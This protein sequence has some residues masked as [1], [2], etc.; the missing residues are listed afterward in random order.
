M[1][2]T[3]ITN[4]YVQI[5]NQDA[6]GLTYDLSDHVQSVD[7]KYSRATPDSTSMGATSQGRM[8]GLQDCTITLN[9]FQDYAAGKVDEALWA[10]FNASA[11]AEI[12]IKPA[13]TAVSATNPRYYGNVI[14]SN[15]TPAS[16]KVGDIA[17]Q[18]ITLPADGA[19]TRSIT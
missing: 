18:N 17:M 19:I 3:T 9:L 6:G 15:Y 8:S 10:L 1:A 16:G 14:L 7:I 12:T 4:A 11:S 5:I 13:N 2:K